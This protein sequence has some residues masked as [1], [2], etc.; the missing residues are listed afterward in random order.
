[1]YVLLRDDKR[2]VIF[3]FANFYIT[4]KLITQSCMHPIA[5]HGSKNTQDIG[6]DYTL[7]RRVF[8]EPS[9]RMKS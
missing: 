8:W 6:D 1:M 3:L 2:I 4:L 9:C 5:R 7:N